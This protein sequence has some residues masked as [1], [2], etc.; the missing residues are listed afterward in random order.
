MLNLK[1]KRQTARLFI[2]L[3]VPEK[4]RKAIK[5]RTSSLRG[6][7]GNIRWESAG[8]FHI[9]LRF[10]G[11][12]RRAEIG[13]ITA[14]VRRCCEGFSP[15]NI[16][17]S[18]VEALIRKRYPETLAVIVEAENSLFDLKDAIDS[19]LESIGFEP[20]KRDFIP[21]ITI[22]RAKKRM[23]LPELP[24]FEIGFTADTVCLMESELR[25][26]G[27]VHMNLRNFEMGLP[28]AE[29]TGEN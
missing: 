26:E 20:E 16:K 28:E 14:A 19:A 7:L 9:T 11:Q 24:C 3:A 10:L 25:R 21:H 23:K 6:S 4:T 15:Q 17:T 8:K 27:A 12:T 29:Q 18:G 5:S 1:D 13:A 22:G 2:S